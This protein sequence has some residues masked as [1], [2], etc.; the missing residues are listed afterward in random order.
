VDISWLG[1]Y[2]P[3]YYGDPNYPYAN[4]PHK[5]S[6]KREQSLHQGEHQKETELAS[7]RFGRGF[8][9][10]FGG[11]LIAGSLIGAGLAGGY[12][13]GSP[14]PPPYY[15]NASHKKSLMRNKE[16]EFKKGEGLFTDAAIGTA[17]VGQ[18]IVNTGLAVTNPYNYGPRPYYYNNANASHRHRGEDMPPR[19]T[20]VDKSSLESRATCHSVDRPAR[21]HT[22]TMDQTKSSAQV[23]TRASVKA[24]CPYVPDN[25]KVEHIANMHNV[26]NSLRDK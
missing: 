23:S 7:P 21:T 9:G 20:R 12:G 13:Y 4:G 5:K 14:Y 8:G 15:A 2:P 26:V 22:K 11:G 16:G 24:S 6:T 19:L 1:A 18:G 17:I 3:E 25:A 10:G